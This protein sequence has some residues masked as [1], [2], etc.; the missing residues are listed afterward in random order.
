MV[1]NKV[2]KTAVIILAAGLGKRMNSKK[3]KV[4]NKINQVP[5][6]ISVC[7]AAIN[8]VGS[9]VIIVIGYK[10]EEVKKI[11]SQKYEL[12]FVL[13][14]KQLG[15]AHAVKCAIPYLPDYI[16][17]IIILYGDIPFLKSSTILEFINYHK[18]YRQDITVLGV[19]VRNPTGYGRLII[20][21]SRGLSSIV[22]EADTSSEQKKI[23]I[24]NSGIYCIEKKLLCDYINKIKPNNAQNEFYLTDIIGIGYKNKRRLGVFIKDESIEFVGINSIEDL[25][26]AEK[27]TTSLLN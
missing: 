14:N 2:D 24:V 17:N 9:D 20:N 10:G 21:N 13:Q 16:E 6:I 7:D 11:V 15:T 23:N 8:S 5:M 12:T 18:L 22:E 25:R 3:P 27:Y 4:L 1:D 19:T 26:Y